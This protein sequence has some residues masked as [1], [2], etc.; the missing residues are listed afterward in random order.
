MWVVCTASLAHRSCT[1]L[2]LT[3]HVN[4][5]HCFA[6][7]R[8]AVMRYDI[9]DAGQGLKSTQ[10]VVSRKEERARCNIGCKQAHRLTYTIKAEVALKQSAERDLQLSSLSISHYNTLPMTSKCS[11][12]SQIASRGNVFSHSAY[13]SNISRAKLV[14]SS[15][16][17]RQVRSTKSFH[18][19]NRGWCDK[20]T[21]QLCFGRTCPTTVSILQELLIDIPTDSR[22]STCPPKLTELNTRESWRCL[23]KNVIR[24]SYCLCRHTPQRLY[25]LNNKSQAHIQW[26]SHYFAEQTF[27]K[28]NHSQ[29]TGG[30]R[31]PNQNAKDCKNFPTD[32][33]LA[34][35]CLWT[36]QCSFRAIKWLLYHTSFNLSFNYTP[37]Q[38][39]YLQS[40]SFLQY[41][42][43]CTF[44]SR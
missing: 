24:T 41:C 2:T 22:N 39:S 23:A 10:P 37:P 40:H 25:K 32:M 6:S 35:Q 27:Y 38:Y 17:I 9:N 3:L 36:L 11:A 42:M 31:Y 30:A 44:L 33:I 15:H 1:R 14:R 16:S 21:T 7:I 34:Y 12:W 29:L 28:S 43:S 18:S 26:S 5:P 8:Y 4:N 20:P 13:E 19:S